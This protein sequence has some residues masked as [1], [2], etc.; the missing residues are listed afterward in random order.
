M[1]RLKNRIKAWWW[2]KI[3]KQAEL[4]ERDTAEKPGYKVIK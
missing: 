4:V 2:I 3:H 1:W